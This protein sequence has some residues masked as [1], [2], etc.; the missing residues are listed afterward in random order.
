MKIMPCGQLLFRM[1]SFLLQNRMLKLI[2]IWKKVNHCV[3]LIWLDGRARSSCTN[4]MRNTLFPEKGSNNWLL[5]DQMLST[6]NHSVGNWKDMKKRTRVSM[7]G[8]LITYMLSN[9]FCLKLSLANYGIWHSLG[10][11]TLLCAK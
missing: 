8:F 10:K 11:Y 3:K 4:W 7:C 2:R 1:R 9:N 5:T 6:S